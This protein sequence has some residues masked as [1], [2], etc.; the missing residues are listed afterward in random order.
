MKIDPVKF[1]AFMQAFNARTSEE[2]QEMA[3]DVGSAVSSSPSFITATLVV[4]ERSDGEIVTAALTGVMVGVLIGMR[5][6][7]TQKME[8]AFS[9]EV[10]A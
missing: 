6:A 4:A 9:A 1:E 2:E 5:Y 10:P 8:E 3:N 7:A